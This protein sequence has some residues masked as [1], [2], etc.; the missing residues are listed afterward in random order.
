[1]SSAGNDITIIPH[2]THITKYCFSNFKWIA[3]IK[4]YIGKKRDD[5]EN[6]IPKNCIIYIL[7]ND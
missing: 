2:T 4:F 1:M 3:L 7:R 6:S 5:S